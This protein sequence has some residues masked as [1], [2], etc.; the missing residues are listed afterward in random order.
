LSSNSASDR[1]SLPLVD[2]YP[3]GLRAAIVVK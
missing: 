1:S 3:N 2:G